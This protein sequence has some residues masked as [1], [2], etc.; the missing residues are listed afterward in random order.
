MQ[1]GSQST[2]LQKNTDGVIS[3]IASRREDTTGDDR[4]ERECKHVNRQKEQHPDKISLRLRLKR[5]EPVHD[6][7]GN[8]DQADIGQPGPQRNAPESAAIFLC[9]VELILPEQPAD[10][11]SRTAGKP[12]CQALDHLLRHAGHSGGGS[13]VRSEMAKDKGVRCDAEAPGQTARKH[14]GNDPPDVPFLR[15]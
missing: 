14:S 1:A 11:D 8:A 15:L 9:L 4:V 6:R 12:R 2:R 5:V 3:R 7:A 10:H 13:R